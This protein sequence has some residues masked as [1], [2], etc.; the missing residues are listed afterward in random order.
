MGAW[1]SGARAAQSLVGRLVGK[2]E[3]G[4]LH[5]TRRWRCEYRHCSDDIIPCMSGYTPGVAVEVTSS[6]AEI[7]EEF[8]V[9]PD[10]SLHIAAAQRCCGKR[11]VVAAR[12]QW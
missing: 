9:D 3:L 12:S 8:F 7:S 4:D 5:Q 2:R 10:E 6:P 1:Q 11:G